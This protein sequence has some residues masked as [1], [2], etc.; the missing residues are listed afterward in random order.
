[1]SNSIPHSIVVIG[2]GNVGRALL[3]QLAGLVVVPPPGYPAFVVVAVANEHGIAIDPLFGFAA[4]QLVGIEWSEE[5]MHLNRYHGFTPQ[6]IVHQVEE[7]VGPGPLT[8][9]DVTAADF[10]DLHLDCLSR[11][12]AVVTANKKP[13]TASMEVWRELMSYGLRRYRFECACGAGLPI[14]STLQD[15]IVT[16]DRILEIQA[17]VSGSLGKILSGDARCFGK[18][19]RDAGEAGYTEPDP[20]D[21]LSGKDVARKALIMARILGRDIELDDIQAESLFPPEWADCDVDEFMDRLVASDDDPDR[22]DGFMTGLRT[23]LIREVNP[24]RYLVDI[25]HTAGQFDVRVGLR[26]AAGRYDS[27]K[28]LQG[29]DNLFRIRTERYEEHPLVIR[30]PGAGPEVTAAGVLADILKIVH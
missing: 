11:G 2:T 25:Y 17:A 5:I 19:V 4:G 8:F 23:R 13:V 30:G 1:M 9:V 28:R 15:M 12:H 14:V 7:E 3:A 21:D 27:F 29:P 20:R 24:A 16:D 26:R 22:Q 6:G 18:S 10:T